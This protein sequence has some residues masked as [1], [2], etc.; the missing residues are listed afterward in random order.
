MKTHKHCTVM[1]IAA[2]IALAVTVT[3]CDNGNEETAPVVCYCS[4]IHGTAAHLGMGEGCGCGGVGCNCTE[5]VASLASIPIRKQADIS[6]QQMNTAV[7]RI[8]AA[9]TNDLGQ[10]EREKLIQRIDVIHIIPGDTATRNGT[11]L[12]I[13]VNA[14]QDD[15]A[16]CFVLTV[17]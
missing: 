1:A 13:G 4:V 17:T 6:V 9:Y 11:T 2:I 3:A 8:N 12:N 7:G 5:Q 10:T 14:A 15:I 16:F